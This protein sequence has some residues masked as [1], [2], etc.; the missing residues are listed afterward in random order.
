MEEHVISATIFRSSKTV[1]NLIWGPSTDIWSLDGQISVKMAFCHLEYTDF[2]GGS[3]CWCSLAE[4]GRVR[5]EDSMTV[6]CPQSSE[7]RRFYDGKLSS[8]SRHSN[9]RLI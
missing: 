6:S 5:Q 9:T 3:S 7:T 2:Q 4:N 1:L 8:K